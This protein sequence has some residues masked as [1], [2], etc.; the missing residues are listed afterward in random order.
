MAPRMQWK[1]QW[2]RRIGLAAVLVVGAALSACSSSEP[3]QQADATAAGT[4][5]A[6][7]ATVGV[8]LKDFGVAAAPA[9]AAAGSVTFSVQNSGAIPH[10]FVVVKSDLA[11][12][13]LPQFEQKIVD[14][15]QVEVIAKT[16]PLDAGKKQDL[17]AMLQPGKYVLICNVASHYVSGMYTAFEV[18]GAA[19]TD[20]Y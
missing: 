18:T 14:E 19:V 15:Q 10:E 1:M 3:A 16:A 7:K 11:A 2:K 5:A 13:K 8:T 20:G 6:A 4:P 12:D 9:S 17:T